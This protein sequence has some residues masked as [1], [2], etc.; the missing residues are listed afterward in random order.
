MPEIHSKALD[1][2]IQVDR[3][4]DRIESEKSGPTMV[5]LAGVHGNEPAGIFALHQVFNELRE[6]KIPIKGSISGI[7]GNLWALE[8]GERFHTKDL[9]RLWTKENIEALE[10]RNFQPDNEDEQEQLSIQNEID[11]ILAKK[12][13]PVYFFDLHTTSGETIPFIT[14]NDSI[15]N[16]K[17]TS[18]YPL[19]SILGIEE[20]LNGP[21]LSYINELG[22]VSFGF[23][24]GQHD[25]IEAIDNHKIFVYLSLV[26]AGVITKDAIPYDDFLNKWRILN[27]GHQVFYEIFE[28]YEI[29]TDELFTMKPG[30]SNFQHISKGEELAVSNGKTLV[31]KKNATLFMPLYQAKGNDG[32]F[33]VKKTPRFFLWLSGVLRRF[34]VDRIFPLLPGVKWSSKEKDTMLVDLRIARFITKPLFHLFGYRSKQVDANFLRIKNRE[35][36]SKMSEYKEEAWFKFRG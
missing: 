36:R 22:Y 20:F 9:N 35:Y 7:S 13:G 4:I 10:K 3:I 2:T 15:L 6:L 1:Q 5:F 16:R 28:R 27:P 23:E 25:A 12:S 24:G 8:H 29:Q 33:L 18:L 17:F 11:A 26:F 34:K 21:L 19:P 31:S 32:Y 30:F 14:V